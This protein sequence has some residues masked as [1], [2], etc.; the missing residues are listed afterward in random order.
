ME[1]RSIKYL[2]SLAKTGS[3]TKA[4]AEQYVTQPAV[5][6]QIRKLEQE[7][8]TRLIERRGREISFTPAGEMV[9]RY[10]EQFVQLEKELYDEMSDLEGIRTGAISLGTIDVAGIY[11]MPQIFSRFRKIYPAV[12]VHLEIAST[13]PLLESLREGK[14]DLVIGT[15]SE[16]EGGLDTFPFYREKLVVIA[17]PGHPL[18]DR[19]NIDVDQLADY[20]FISFHSESVTRGII[21]EFFRSRGIELRITMAMG[22]TEAIK[23]LVASGLGLALL[24]AILVEDEERKGSIIILDVEGMKIERKLGLF[25][26]P[27]HYLPLAARAFLSVMRDGLGL[28]IPAKYCMDDDRK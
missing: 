14:L 13:R 24:P 21:E 5:S 17:P 3:F 11:V 18:A 20:P 28:E 25:L 8:G 27:K 10:A 9:L 2:I 12:D 16:D 6:I 26:M 19:K 23:N 4:A 15:F 22:S 7:L 1:L